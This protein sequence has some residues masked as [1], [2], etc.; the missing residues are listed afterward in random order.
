MR[1]IGFGSD[2]LNRVTARHDDTATVAHGHESGAVQP[3][4]V[5]VLE[6]ALQQAGGLQSSP[7]IAANGG[8]RD[9]D[10]DIVYAVVTRA[11]WRMID[12]PR[13]T[14]HQKAYPLDHIA[15]AIPSLDF[16]KGV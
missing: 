14:D 15:P 10:L 1:L 12:L 2:D 5:G 8:G 3:M 13:A 9:R 16:G 11:G 4:C 7:E 6:D